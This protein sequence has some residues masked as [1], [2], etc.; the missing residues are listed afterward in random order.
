MGKRNL[1]LCSVCKKIINLICLSNR[2]GDE[3][4]LGFIP[5]NSLK[6]VACGQSIHWMDLDTLYPE[7]D[8]ILKPGGCLA[9]YG[10]VARTVKVVDG[11]TALEGRLQSLYKEVCE[12]K[13]LVAHFLSSAS[14]NYSMSSIAG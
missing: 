13:I 3:K 6:L 14:Y 11:E 9:A 2:C 7:I 10:Y 4:D 8:R 5:D 12:L 1:T